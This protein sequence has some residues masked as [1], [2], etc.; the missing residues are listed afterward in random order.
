[1]NQLNDEGDEEWYRKRFG[2]ADVWLIG[3][4]SGA[5]LWPEF[6]ESGIAAI[7]WPALGDLREY[8]DRQ[9]I[10]NALI[11]SYK[12]PNPSND[13][14]ALYEFAHKM[15]I[16]DVLVVK[17]GR[18]TILGWGT[19]TGGYEYDPECIKYLHV[20]SV[21]YLHVRSVKWRP[22]ITPVQTRDPVASKTL[23]RLTRDKKQ[24]RKLRS[25]FR[26]IDDDDG[27]HASGERP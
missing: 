21:E 23:T 25:I 26:S 13:S 3:A 6:R 1:M 18:S 16:K 5:R 7:G 17:Q 27:S 11:E 12:K 22:C 20:R 2:T 24:L 15:S 19:V 8:D 9:D 10:H 14:R 4:Y